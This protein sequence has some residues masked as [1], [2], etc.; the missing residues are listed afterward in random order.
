M[1]VCIHMYTK[2]SFNEN[3][4]LIWICDV[5]VETPCPARRNCW[6]EIQLLPSISSD[7]LHYSDIIQKSSRKLIQR[8][9]VVVA[10]HV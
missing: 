1:N 2:N 6:E 3:G 4:N 10:M 5:P 8:F 7:F 9:R